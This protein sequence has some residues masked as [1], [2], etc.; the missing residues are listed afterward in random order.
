MR[1]LVRKK[2]TEPC[3]RKTIHSL[4]TTTSEIT[5]LPSFTVFPWGSRFWLKLHG[6]KVRYQIFMANWYLRKLTF[7]A[8]LEEYFVFKNKNKPNWSLTIS[9]IQIGK[10]LID[11]WLA[12]TSLPS[13]G[14][15]FH[16]QPTPFDACT[17][18]HTRHYFDV[19]C[20]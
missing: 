20:V 4:S 16:M 15:W 3:V 14:C 13:I 18:Q 11:V 8:L 19:W 1:L 12:L 2:N 10:I 6:L 5:D 17:C 7:L 9:P